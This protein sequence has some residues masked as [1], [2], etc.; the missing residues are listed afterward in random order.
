MFFAVDVD[1][2]EE[3]IGKVIPTLFCRVVLIFQLSKLRYPTLQVS[4]PIVEA[5]LYQ[6][7][8]ISDCILGMFNPIEIFDNFSAATAAWWTWW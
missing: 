7:Y 6:I 4:S 2:T 8:D 1:L 5:E 3:G